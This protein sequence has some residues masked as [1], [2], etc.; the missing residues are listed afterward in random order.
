MPRDSCHKSGFPQPV[1]KWLWESPPWKRPALCCR[2]DKTSGTAL[3]LHHR[4][5]LPAQCEKGL[6]LPG[7]KN[8]AIVSIAAPL[9]KDCLVK[10]TPH[11]VSTLQS[12]FIIAHQGKITTLIIFRSAF[13]P[14]KKA[15][16]F[17]LPLFMKRRKT[18]NSVSA[19]LNL[20]RYGIT[21][22]FAWQGILPLSPQVLFPNHPFLH[23]HPWNPGLRHRLD[24]RRQ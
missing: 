15:A 6:R 20:T 10:I 22:P 24:R 11:T 5:G 17:S 12:H 21:A 18:L 8:P 16:T 1:W 2:Q 19:F 9:T 13:T 23:R 7:Q 14:F 4:S 3:H